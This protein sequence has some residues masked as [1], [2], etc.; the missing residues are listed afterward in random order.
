VNFPFLSDTAEIPSTRA[1]CW[2]L[3]LMV[4]LMASFLLVIDYAKGYWYPTEFRPLRTFFAASSMGIVWVLIAWWQLHRLRRKRDPTLPKWPQFSLWH[5]FVLMSLCAMPAM[6]AG[7]DYQQ[8]QREYAACKRLNQ[9]LAPMLGEAGGIHRNSDGLVIT[10]C[11]PTFDD[12]D[13]TELAEQIQAEQLENKVKGIM[14]A[15][16]ADGLAHAL[17]LDVTDRSLEHFSR[18]P[19]LKQIAIDGTSISREGKLF[20][21]ESLRLEEWWKKNLVDTKRTIPPAFPQNR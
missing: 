17:W 2:R 10:I 1:L 9:R 4:V 21:A 3:L 20:L 15:F 13:F 7:L 18:W 11:E 14:F 5:L 12:V 19:N 6:F 8:T 16:P